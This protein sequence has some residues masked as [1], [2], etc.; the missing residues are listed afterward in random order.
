LSC[1]KVVGVTDGYHEM[2]NV[3]TIESWAGRGVSH[4]CSPLREGHDAL[5]VPCKYGKEGSDLLVR[6]DDRENVRLSEETG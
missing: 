1:S 4:D 5:S 2:V 3:E 6:I